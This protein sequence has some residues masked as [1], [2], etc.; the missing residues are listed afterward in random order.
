MEDVYLC[1]GYRLGCWGIVYL[2]YLVMKIEKENSIKIKV[3]G[4]DMDNFKSAIKK[5]VTENDKI[6]F[7]K[8]SF[9]D[10]EKKV[11]KDISDKL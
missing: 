7:N 8:I 3:K 11:L 2:Y 5:V 4:D 6:G 1:G 9:T 10:E